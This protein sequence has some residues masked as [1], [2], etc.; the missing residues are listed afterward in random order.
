MSYYAQHV[1]DTLDG[2]QTAELLEAAEGLHLYPP[3]ILAVTTGLRRGEVLGLKWSDIDLEP[4]PPE[5]PR[6]PT[7]QVRRS[8]GQVKGKV[9]IKPPKT[10]RAAAPSFCWTSPC[11]N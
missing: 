9:T 3:V 2:K 8:V 4:G 11:E 6:D 1:M 5:K 10:K 7:L